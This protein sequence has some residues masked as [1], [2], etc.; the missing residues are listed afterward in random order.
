MCAAIA[1]PLRLLNS[2]FQD[3]VPPVPDFVRVAVKVPRA[4]LTSPFGDG[5]SLA[6]VI[7]AP[8]RIVSAWL[9]AAAPP[10]AAS[11]NASPTVPASKWNLRI[12]SSSRWRDRP[13]TPFGVR[14]EGV[15]GS[16]CRG[17]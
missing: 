12:H 4:P 14:Y 6:A 13:S 3:S 8:I 17:R 1:L 2:S 15:E 5:V 9:L 7:A 10:T 16:D 11:A